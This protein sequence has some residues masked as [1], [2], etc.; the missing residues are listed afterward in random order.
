[1][2][3]YAAFLTV[4]RGL[5]KISTNVHT[6]IAILMINDNKKKKLSALLNFYFLVNFSLCV[7]VIDQTVKLTSCDKFAYILTTKV[8]VYLLY[9]IQ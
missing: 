5:R 8:S 3:Q 4:I 9:I 2:D 6:E 7:L 1:V